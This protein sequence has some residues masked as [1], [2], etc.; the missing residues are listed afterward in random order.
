M[1]SAVP[2]LRKSAAKELIRYLTADTRRQMLTVKSIP[3]SA[4]RPCGFGTTDYRLLTSDQGPGIDD[5]ESVVRSLLSLYY[6]CS[7]LSTCNSV[8]TCA[9]RFAIP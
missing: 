4:K 8:L 9:M 7:A 2:N 1:R 6:P 5:R 3:Q